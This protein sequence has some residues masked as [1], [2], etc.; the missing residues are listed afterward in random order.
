[1]F[2][3]LI[4]Y[5]RGLKEIIEHYYHENAIYTVQGTDDSF[6]ITNHPKSNDTRAEIDIRFIWAP[7]Y[8]PVQQIIDIRADIAIIG[9]MYWRHDN[10]SD[11]PAALN[12]V[13]NNVTKLFWLGT[14]AQEGKDVKFYA[15]RNSIMRSWAAQG[16]KRAYVALELLASSNTF[17][18]NQV[19]GVHFQCSTL[20]IPFGQAVEYANIKTP[21]DGDCR[22]LF[23]LNIV[24]LILNAM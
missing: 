24:Q 20:S 22:D 3:R 14:P 2:Q 11:V 13:I 18:R 17:S 21:R 23:N 1:V 9:L 8:V 16:Q 5:I 6:L 15:E 4:W 12:N 7:G 10:L 19:D